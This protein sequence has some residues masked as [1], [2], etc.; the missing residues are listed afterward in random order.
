VSPSARV[1]ITFEGESL[2]TFDIEKQLV[3]MEAVS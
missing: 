2:A 3:T 1:D